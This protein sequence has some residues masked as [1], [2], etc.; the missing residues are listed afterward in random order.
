MIYPV[1]GGHH[2]H[3]KRDKDFVQCHLD[4]AVRKG[5][6]LCVQSKSGSLSHEVFLRA[7]REGCQ[8]TVVECLDGV[9]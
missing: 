6:R 2:E 1:Q 9:I 4:K 5:A 3:S 8:K 7:G